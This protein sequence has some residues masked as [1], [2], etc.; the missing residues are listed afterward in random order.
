MNNDF[1]SLYQGWDKTMQGMVP[2]SERGAYYDFMRMGTET[3]LAAY[4]IV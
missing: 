2:V 1:D 3:S 4:L